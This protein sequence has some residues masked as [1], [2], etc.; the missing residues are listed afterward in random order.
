M[1]ECACCPKYSLSNTYIRPRT[2]CCPLEGHALLAY[3]TLKRKPAHRHSFTRTHAHSL[4]FVFSSV[5]ALKQLFGTPL[6]LELPALSKTMSDQ[7]QQLDGLTVLADDLSLAAH[8]PALEYPNAVKA[9]LRHNKLIIKENRWK[10]ITINLCDF[11]TDARVTL[12][13]LINDAGQCYTP[14]RSRRARLCQVGTGTWCWVVTSIAR[15]TSMLRNYERELTTTA[16]P[17]RGGRGIYIG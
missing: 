17:T 13:D 1:V 8:I 5:P 7:S 6:L 10:E 3:M 9:A 4:L 11:I 12:R 15:V 16:R 2:T 14:C